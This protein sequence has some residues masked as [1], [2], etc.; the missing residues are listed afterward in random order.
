[1]EKTRKCNSR[2][3]Q[4]TLRQCM[5]NE[6]E[7]EVIEC[8]SGG[9]EL[10]RA[11]RS[12]PSSLLYTGGLRLPTTHE[13]FLRLIVVGDNTGRRHRFLFQGT[14]IVSIRRILDFDSVIP[15][16]GMDRRKCSCHIQCLSRR[17]CA[18][19]RLRA[20]TTLFSRPK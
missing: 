5:T 17:F 19:T 9:R 6:S 4:H 12:S 11:R 18:Y 13:T 8:C 2:T 16:S 15:C 14:G 3:E 1:M 10:T 7:D 20:R